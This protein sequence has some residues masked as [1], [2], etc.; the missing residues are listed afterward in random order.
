MSVKMNMWIS[1]WAL[2]R[3]EK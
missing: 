2:K 1:E 3:N